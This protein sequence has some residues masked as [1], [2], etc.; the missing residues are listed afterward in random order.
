MSQ[1]QT[2][3]GVEAQIYQGSLSPSMALTTTAS[4]S[5]FSVP[6]SDSI[7]LDSVCACGWEKQAKPN[8]SSF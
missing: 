1:V 6:L 3:T 7:H 8:R 4:S 2:P 5:V